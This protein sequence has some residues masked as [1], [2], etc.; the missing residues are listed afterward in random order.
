MGHTSGS[1]VACSLLTSKSANLSL[2][3]SI[4]TAGRKQVTS[5]PSKHRRVVSSGNSFNL[6]AMK[7]VESRK[8]LSC[9]VFTTIHINNTHRLHCKRT[10]NTCNQ[11]NPT[12][13][14]NRLLF[15]HFSSTKFCPYKA[16]RHVSGA[17]NWL[18]HCNDDM[19]TTTR[20]QL[21]SQA[22]CLIMM[23]EKIY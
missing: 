1:C 5:S 4:R 8:L 22:G 16:S 15:K 17:H 9:K 23:K 20:S 18:Q 3:H 21:E 6:R 7:T 2:Q 14:V 10:S 11:S 13:A 19:T 12:E